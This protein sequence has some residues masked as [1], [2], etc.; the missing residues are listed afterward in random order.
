M[1]RGDTSTI[2]MSIEF[3]IYELPRDELGLVDIDLEGDSTP[4]D[5]IPGLHRKLS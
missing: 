5:G 2:E 3:G 1:V 4:S